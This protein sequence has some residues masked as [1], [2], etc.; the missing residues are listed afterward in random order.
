[1]IFGGRVRFDGERAR[2]ITRENACDYAARLRLIESDQSV[3]ECQKL[4]PA[5]RM[6]RSPMIHD[7]TSSTTGP[8]W[9]LTSA[10][11]GGIAGLPVCLALPHD[12]FICSFLGVDLT[13]V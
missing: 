10:A 11:A 13:S 2:G 9:A 3:A 5:D 8:I 12:S 7:A 6:G 1:M 4:L